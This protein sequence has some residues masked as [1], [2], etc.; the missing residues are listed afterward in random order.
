MAMLDDH[1]RRMMAT[2]KIEQNSEMMQSV[3]EH[4]NSPSEDVVVMPVGEPRKWGRVRKSTS[5]QR[6]EPKE[7]NRKNCG[8]QTKLAAACR[9][10]SRH[11]T[12]VW[13]KRNLIRQIRISTLAAASRRM[14]RS[15]KMARG[16]EHELQKEKTRLHRE[17]GKD[18]RRKINI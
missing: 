4:Q 11:A 5:G 6:G 10:V 1:Q 3:V 9:K 8:S 12:V 7:L 14:S 15:A 2:K 18:E 17:P 16:T 13:R